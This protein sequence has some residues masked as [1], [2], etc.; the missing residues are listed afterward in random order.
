[1][2]RIFSR[3]NFHLVQIESLRFQL[4]IDSIVRPLVY[5]YCF[6]KITDKR[7]LELSHFF[8]GFEV[9]FSIEVG[10]HSNS[11]PGKKNID[12]R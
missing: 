5:L 8:A 6:R 12:Q 1:M 11:R 9:I 3:N 10:G 7:R 4:K 2:C